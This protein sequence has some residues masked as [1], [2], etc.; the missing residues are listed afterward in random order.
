MSTAAVEKP[1]PP[2]N[3]QMKKNKENGESKKWE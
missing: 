3:N 2:S 1:N